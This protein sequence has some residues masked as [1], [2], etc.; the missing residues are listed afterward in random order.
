MTELRRIGRF[1]R[2]VLERM[3][4]GVLSKVRQRIDQL[5]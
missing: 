1:A 4:K 2:P 3:R 5:L